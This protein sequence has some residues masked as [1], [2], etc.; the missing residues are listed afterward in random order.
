M[1]TVCENDLTVAQKFAEFEK[2]NGP[3]FIWGRA[4]SPYDGCF[5]LNVVA[6]VKNG[7]AYIT[8]DLAR[9]RFKHR[10][11]QSAYPNIPSLCAGCIDADNIEDVIEDIE[12]HPLADL[13]AN[14]PH[15]HV[16]NVV[17]MLDGL[18]MEYDGFRCA[19]CGYVFQS[20]DDT[21]YLESEFRGNGGIGIEVGAPI[22]A[23]CYCERRCGYCGAEVEVHQNCIDDE[24]H[25]IYCAPDRVDENGEKISLDYD[26]TE[27]DIKAYLNGTEV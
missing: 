18:G 22:C 24:G 2:Q 27:E 16:K 10:R 11:A 3:S 12:F 9:T 15:A 6:F 19:S 25:C 4:G 20:H 17:D 21:H 8:L 1:N 26:S 5:W 13:C 7:R 23:D 14:T